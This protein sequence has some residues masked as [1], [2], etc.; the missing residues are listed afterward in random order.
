M[1]NWIILLACSCTVFP[2]SAETLTYLDNYGNGRIAYGL[3][4]ASMD[5]Y[6]TLANDPIGNLP[7]DFTICSA[8]YFEYRT[9]IA[10]FLQLYQADGS[11]WINF[12]MIDSFLNDMTDRFKIVFNEKYTNLWPNEVPVV[13]HSWYRGCVGVDTIS[14]MVRIY[15]EGSK[16]LD[17]E[18]DYFKNSMATKPASLKNHLGVFKSRIPGLWYNG[19]GR[20]S[21]IQV[22]S[23]LL[24][25][26]EMIHIT[27]NN[28]P[29]CIVEG[30]Y[31]AWS[32]MEWDITGE[33]IEGQLEVGD[34]CE[35]KLSSTVV[36][37]IVF[38]QWESCMQ[39]CPKMDKSR[40]PS[41]MNEEELKTLKD[42]THKLIFEGKEIK[43]KAYT[44]WLPISDFKEEGTF[45]DYYTGEQTSLILPLTGRQENCGT[46]WMHE[47]PPR[48][49]DWACVV[50]PTH[51]IKCVCQHPRRIYLKLRGLCTTSNIDRYY[52]PGNQ[53]LSGNFIM[54]GLKKT[55]IEFDRK[56]YTWNLQ[57]IGIGQK[58]VASSKA[59]EIS[60]LLGTHLWTI[61]EDHKGCS[62]LGVSYSKFLKL[63]G[64]AD[65]E[66]TCRDGQCISMAKRCD[67]VTNCRDKSDEDKCSLLV[68]EDGY[69]MK[70]APFEVDSI[71]E[72][73]V[74]AQ[75]NISTTLFNV[76]EISEQNHKITLKFRI[77][78]EWYE[79][80]AIY[81]NL[82]QKVSFNYLS[83]YEIGNLWT[84][85]VIYKNTDNN[86][87]ITINDGVRTTMAITREGDFIRSQ[88]DV[89]DEI[90]IFNGRDNRVTMNQTYSKEFQ[91]KYQL[92]WF[93]FDTQVSNKIQENICFILICSGLLHSH[94]FARF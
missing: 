70:V 78:L 25:S 83:N 47:N 71:T 20:I 1:N 10:V 11:P 65:D 86:D 52:S 24:S 17:A 87:A 35:S 90:E 92:H 32:D 88:M 48:L 55:I 23:K 22:H 14:G 59:P 29:N 82:K 79:N 75:V 15:V 58:T 37:H 60:I 31:L 6:A 41:V 18:F 21:D 8:V 54:I 68:L 39:L 28:N 53:K 46:L 5:R 61:E 2:A 33:V 36:L 80:R 42:V 67:Q 81:H 93:P 30:D 56:S 84:P 49:D 34:L 43:P 16:I 72:E 50:P 64:C 51:H 4:P 44:L 26:D 73:V 12:Y 91:C 85:Y 76:I 62:D 13:P 89:V 57:V 38:T 77:T 9:S 7:N 74:A 63:A 40:A 27:S 45:V 94:D 3:A 69:N 19:R 66:Y